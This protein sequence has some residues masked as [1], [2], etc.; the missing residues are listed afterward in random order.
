MRS[1]HPNPIGISLGP[2]GTPVPLPRGGNRACRALVLR[3]RRSE[4]DGV[5]W[6]AER[7]ITVD[8]ST[9]DA[10][11]RTFAQRAPAA[12]KRGGTR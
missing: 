3:Y 4:V 5:E 11:V 10:W 1:A 9:V 8:P 2:E 7:S 12:M 6:L